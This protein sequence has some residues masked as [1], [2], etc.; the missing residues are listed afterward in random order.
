MAR[1]LYQ[2]RDARGESVTGVIAAASLDEAGQLLR[3]EGKF[4]VRL[5]ATQDERSSAGPRFGG[6]RIRRRDVIFFIQQ[7]SVMLETGVSMSDAMQCLV[8]QCGNPAF[9]TVLE[10]VLRHVQSGSPL[11]QAMARHPKVFPRLVVALIHAS[12]MSGTMGVML[13]RIS[14]YL[15]REQQILRQARGALMYPLFMMMM[16]IG[17]TV[18]LLTVVLP[19]FASIYDSRKA[20]LPA[21]TRLLL[22]ISGSLTH[23]WYFWLA[24]AILLVGGAYALGRV[25]SG[26]R[27]YDWLKLHAPIAKGL[28]SRLYLTRACRTMGT[29][30]GAGVSM[31]DMVQIVKQVTHNIYFEELRTEVERQLTRGSQ[32]SDPLF[33]S[34]LIPR[35]VAQMIF[36]GEKAGRLGQVMDRVAGFTEVEFEQSVKTA[37]QFIEPVM[38]CVMGGLIGFVAISLLLPIFNVGRV[39]AGG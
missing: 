25:D 23:Y 4:I 1:F 34:D 36:S 33:A 20:V 21:P 37:T 14:N 27:F 31:L 8:A 7:M 32:L 16:T 12:E 9:K 15:S 18:F 13:D 28:F 6:G 17:V 19:R 10:D 24:G 39:M 11:S 38:I 26:R 2:A 30:I 3:A 35:P 29:L 5:A 22:A